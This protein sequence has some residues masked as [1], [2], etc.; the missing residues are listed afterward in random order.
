MT[1]EVHILVKFIPGPRW[2]EFSKYVSGHLAVLT[3]GMKAGHIISAGPAMDD[4]GNLIGGYTRYSSGSKK[5]VEAL[6][7]KDPLIQ[8]SVMTYET[9]IWLDCHL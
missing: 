3:S 1:G 4:D 5:E 6:V 9:S 8:N 7:V 2:S